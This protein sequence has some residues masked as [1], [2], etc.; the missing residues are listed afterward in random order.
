M[1]FFGN[2]EST[3]KWMLAFRQTPF[4][5]FI[6]FVF[7]HRSTANSILDNLLLYRLIEPALYDEIYSNVNGKASPH[8]A[9]REELLEIFV[10][11]KLFFMSDIECDLFSS[12]VPFKS[13]RNAPA[14][15]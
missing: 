2:S 11:T 13:G 15:L 1:V 14:F 7:R 4:V 6:S 8:S 3:R 5:P 12:I 10:G 9:Q